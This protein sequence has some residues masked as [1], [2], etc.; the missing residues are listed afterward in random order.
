MESGGRVGAVG[1]G[2][3]TTAKVLTPPAFQASVPM[4]CV[5]SRVAKRDQDSVA[6]FPLSLDFIITIYK[7]LV[8]LVNCLP[9]RKRLVVCLVF[10][11]TRF[12]LDLGEGE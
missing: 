9:F 2:T 1:S 4:T 8:K 5:K 12:R 7:E 11:G 6:L 3:T 10:R